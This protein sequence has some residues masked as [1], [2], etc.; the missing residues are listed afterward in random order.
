MLDKLIRDDGF[1]P[2]HEPLACKTI[3][4][5]RG[6]SL[7]PSAVRHLGKMGMSDA[8]F[9]L[10]DGG[11]GW[12]LLS[13]NR[14]CSDSSALVLDPSGKQVGPLLSPNLSLDRT[15]FRVR[16]HPDSG[17][18]IETEEG[19]MVFDRAPPKLLYPKAVFEITREPPVCIPEVSD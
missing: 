9:C 5:A 15:F 10:G 14:P 17:L 3:T 2:I 11:G 19:I 1:E 12:R 8:L 16:R 13:I 7:L 18:L 6:R 4:A